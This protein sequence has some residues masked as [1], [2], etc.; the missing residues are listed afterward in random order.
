M[1]MDFNIYHYVQQY[2]RYV[3]AVSFIGWL[4]GFMLL[5]AG[6]VYFIQHYVIKFVS[7]LWQDGGFL[8][9]LRLPPPIKLMAT[10]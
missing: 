9:V 10:I 2:F 4:V 7:D 6:E 5:N 3:V 8:K 1:I